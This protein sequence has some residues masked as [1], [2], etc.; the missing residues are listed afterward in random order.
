M[1]ALLLTSL[2]W[3]QALALASRGQPWFGLHLKRQDR[4]SVASRMSLLAV[5]AVF[6]VR[7]YAEELWRC[8]RT[9]PTVRPLPQ[10]AVPATQTLRIPPED[11][12]PP[13]DQRDATSAG[14]TARP[15]SWI[16]NTAA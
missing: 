6:G 12:L 4:L 10:P 11:G 14:G 13:A 7:P 2:H 5:M 8:W 16:V 1:A 15:R 3:D 9:T